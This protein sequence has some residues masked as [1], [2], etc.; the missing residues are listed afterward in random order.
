MR[1]IGGPYPETWSVR[2]HISDR[3]RTRPGTFL[4]A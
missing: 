4:P 1:F 2:A 3:R